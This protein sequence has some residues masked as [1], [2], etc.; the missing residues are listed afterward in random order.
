[1]PEGPPTEARHASHLAAEALKEAE[2]RGRESAQLR[3]DVAEHERHFARLNHSLDKFDAR[4]VTLGEKIDEVEE[5]V[6]NLATAFKVYVEVATALA[7]A[8]VDAAA[9]TVTTR[10]FL[11]SL[12]VAVV[13]VLTYLAAHHP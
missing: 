10:T 7:K 11:I 12:V 5:K 9:K 8:A 4:L 6:D 1:M 3:S 2:A 13:I